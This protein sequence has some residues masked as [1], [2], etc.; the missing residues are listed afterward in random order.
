MSTNA[1][2]SNVRFPAGP[3]RSE[4]S[5]VLHFDYPC[6]VSAEPGGTHVVRFP[7]VPE[8]LGVGSD[9]AE[10]LTMARYVLAAALGER[11]IRLKPLPAPS[12]ASATDEQM[13]FSLTLTANL[14]P[15]HEG[16]GC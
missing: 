4:G 5:S 16:N 8:A 14:R 1:N 10:A 15:P 7:D 9:R 3:A 12:P 11:L 13:T 6:A 2:M